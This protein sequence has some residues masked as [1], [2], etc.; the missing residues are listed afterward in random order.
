MGESSVVLCLCRGEG[1]Y[2][3]SLEFSDPRL[4]DSR[5]RRIRKADSRPDLFTAVREQLSLQLQ[6][7]NRPLE[8]VVID[9]VEKDHRRTD[10]QQVYRAVT[11]FFIRSQMPRQGRGRGAAAGD[12]P[13]AVRGDVNGRS[14]CGKHETQID[15]M[16]RA[17]RGAAALWRWRYANGARATTSSDRAASAIRNS[18]S[19]FFP[20]AAN[21]SAP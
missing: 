8:F 6:A 9:H 11:S 10:Y 19:R 12:Q 17:C 15:R 3:Y 14:S 7:A 2:T 21:A 18:R 13:A 16:K 4:T 1:S 20:G 5:E